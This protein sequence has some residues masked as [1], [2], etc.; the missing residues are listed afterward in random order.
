[1]LLRNP[2][3]VAAYLAASTLVFPQSSTADAGF[4]GLGFLPG[5]SSSEANAISADGSTVVGGSGNGLASGTQAFKWTSGGGMVG[6]GTLPGGQASQ[7]YAV[8][9]DGSVVAGT[10]SPL[11]NDLAFRWTASGGMVNLGVVDGGADAYG[12]SS[13]GSVVVGTS[14]YA[15]RWTASGGMVVLGLLPQGGYSI[16]QGVSADGS[17]VVGYGDGLEPGET[18]PTYADAFRWTASGGMVGLGF[19]EPPPNGIASQAMA[20]SA[21][22]SVVV[23]S[24]RTSSGD[25]AFRWTPGRGM[26]GL[27]TLPSLYSSYALGVSA[28]GT[29]AVGYGESSSGFT[30]L[31]WAKNQVFSVQQLLTDAGLDLTGWTLQQANAI[32]E[33]DLTI[34]GFGLDPNGHQEAWIAT[35]PPIP[36]E[37][38]L[39]P[40]PAPILLTLFWLRRW[41]RRG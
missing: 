9:S 19:L 16:A 33:D 27:G 28:D 4:T 14:Q 10:S 36:A 37:C 21:D 39:G 24:S 30:A 6:L 12:V 38:G 26:V 32:A 25:Q 23:G 31:I 2:L 40:E 18:I 1:L 34:V 3:L 8:S 13:D 5:G 20:T 11:G 17:V 7:A 41:R 22:G 29:A 35:L 15:F